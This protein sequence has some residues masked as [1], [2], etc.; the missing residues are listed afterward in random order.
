MTFLGLCVS[1]PVVLYGSSGSA[2]MKGAERQRENGGLLGIADYSGHL[3]KLLCLI[4]Y[5]LGLFLTH[6]NF[7]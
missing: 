5:Y 2:L 4:A 3:V 1:R 6:E 7:T